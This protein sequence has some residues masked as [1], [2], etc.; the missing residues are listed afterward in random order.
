MKEKTKEYNLKGGEFIIF[1]SEESC[2]VIQIPAGQWHSLEVLESG[3]IIFEA[4]DGAYEPLGD[5]DILL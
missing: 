2:S 4:K 5:E 1:S 3:T